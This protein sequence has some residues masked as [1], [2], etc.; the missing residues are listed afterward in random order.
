MLGIKI[1]CKKKLIRKVFL[2]F[3]KLKYLMFFLI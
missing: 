1:V 2:Y 3:K